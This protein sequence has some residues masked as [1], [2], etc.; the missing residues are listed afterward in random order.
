MKSGELRR[1]LWFEVEG[2]EPDISRIVVILD[3]LELS[4]VQESLDRT[5]ELKA[6][7]DQAEYLKEN[8]LDGTDFIN[9]EIIG[10]DGGEFVTGS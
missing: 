7:D 8:R 1:I 2:V 4:T 9:G 3:F 5:V 6:T 10:V